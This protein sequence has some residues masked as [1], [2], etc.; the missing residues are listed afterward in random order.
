MI[1]CREGHERCAV[2]GIECE[3]EVIAYSE[4]MDDQ[5]PTCLGCGTVNPLTAPSGFLAVTIT[6]CPTCD[7]LGYV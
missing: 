4:G 2:D 6:R 7:G 5:C 3:C 1:S